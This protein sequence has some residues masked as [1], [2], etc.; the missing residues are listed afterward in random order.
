MINIFQPSLGIEELNRVNEVFRSNWIGKGNQVL[1]FEKAFA[2]SLGADSQ[3]FTSTTSCTEGLF[4]ATELFGIGPGDEVIVPTVSFVGVGSAVIVSGAKLVFCDVD[5]HSL[6]VTAA[7]IADK[8]TKNTKA[9]YVT[10]Y[11][12]VSCDMDPIL[13]YCRSREIVVIE[14][15]A[16]AVRSFYKG[17][18][19][20]TLG[21]MGAWSFDAMK[22]VCTGDGGMLYLR[23]RDLLEVAKEWLYLG[24]PGKQKSGMDSSG[25][26]AVNWWEF[27]VMRPGHRAVMNNIAGAIGLAQMEKLPNF[28]ARRR[29]I[30]ERYCQEL[31]DLAWLRLPPPIPEDYES[32]YYFCWLQTEA[33][34]RLAKYLLD[35]GVYSTFRYWPLHKVSLFSAKIG[36]V[37]EFPNAE[38]ACRRTLNIPLHQSLSDDD[39]SKVID[40]IRNFK[41]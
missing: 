8:V 12:G 21:D 24:L 34:D 4:L 23:N 31:A 18:A 35:N 38:Q 1:D 39:V 15:A 29:A 41:G 13:E 33:R 22:I 16:C 9:V 10:H 7:H 20:G 27:D 37:F 40:L 28:L 36:E 5:E 25:T 32:S 19:C 30:Y 14:D 26:G 3:Y 2:A 6:N 17:R 11:G